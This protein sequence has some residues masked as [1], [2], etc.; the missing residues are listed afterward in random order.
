MKNVK[1]ILASLV[2]LPAFAASPLQAMEKEMECKMCQECAMCMEKMKAKAEMKAMQK[3]LAQEMEQKMSR[4]QDGAS[5][6]KQKLAEA[7][8]DAVLQQYR[9]VRHMEE[10]T[11]TEL[12][13]LGDT[14][15][16]R[17]KEIG[18]LSKRLDTLG[19]LA[20]DLRNKAQACCAMDADKQKEAA[21]AAHEHGETE[22]PVEEKAAAAPHH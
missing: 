1:S 3:K 19:K 13:L 20:E 16:D 22:K 4:K 14:A 21:P 12:K 2:L 9:K 8:L 6:V 15:G 5:Q 7:D 11:K 10:E 18:L 17:A